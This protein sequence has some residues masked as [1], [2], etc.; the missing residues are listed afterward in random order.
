MRGLHKSKRVAWA[1]DVNLCQVRLFLSEE[2]PTQVGLGAQDHLQAK[3]S[4]VLHSTGPGSDG[5]LPPGFE[6]S[7]PDKQLQIKLSQIHLIK[8]RSPSQFVLDFTW[9]VVAGEES[10]E[11]EVQSQR[12][13]RVLEAV[14]PRPSA[15]PPN[16]S[17][18]VDTEDLMHKDEQ[19]LLIP[20]TPIEDEDVAVDISPDSVVPFNVPISHQSLLLAPGIPSPS[21]GSLPTIA[22]PPVQKPPAAM[23]VGAQP[24][25]VASASAAINAIGKTNE[26]GNLIDPELLI[27]ILSN[28]KMIEKLVT[29]YGMATNTQDLPKASSPPVASSDQHPV[30]IN[31]RVTGTP[32]SATVL[33]GPFYPKPNGVG[34]QHPNPPISPPPVVPVSAPP[35]VGAPP[36]KDINYY[37]SLIQQHGEERPEALPQYGNRHSHQSGANQEL[38]NNH[39]SRDLRPRIMKPCIYF[40]S[41][42]GCRNGANCAY[43]HDTSFQQRGSSV[44]ETQSAKRM[45]L[46]REIS[47]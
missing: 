10:K 47:S 2:S 44:P 30:P 25:V 5:N 4:L 27:T 40:N 3:T 37:K 7:H 46:N 6:G 45:K 20:L 33:G 9:Q 31:R 26:H 15:I 13:M 12:E 34:V 21:Q 17:V 8:W 11:S 16:P 24:D 41:S 14:Y 29:D 35:P 23:V 22:N 19:T 18:S 43:Q 39:K 36:A 38:T 28:P 32:S 42:R 1:S